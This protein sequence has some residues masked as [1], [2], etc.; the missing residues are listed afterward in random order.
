MDVGV[1]SGFLPLQF[2]R[3]RGRDVLEEKQNGRPVKA[4]PILLPVSVDTAEQAEQGRD[5]RS[6]GRWQRLKQSKVSLFPHRGKT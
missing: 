2:T 6:Q 3:R 1:P 5:R 4:A